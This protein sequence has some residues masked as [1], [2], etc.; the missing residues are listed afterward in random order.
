MQKNKITKITLIGR[1]PS[2]KNQ[3]CVFVR[4]GKIVNIPS[5]AYREWHSS[6]LEQLVEYNGP[7]KM[8]NVKEI[9]LCFYAP[10]KRANDLSNKAESIMDL[11][12][13]KDILED[14]NWFVVPKLSLVFKGI[15]RD[16]PRCEILIERN[17]E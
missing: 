3:R 12:V 15:D 6:A 7:T 9:T 16:N 10:D 14:D 11:L 5:K 1:V 17:N 4:N 8:N 13:D 2:K